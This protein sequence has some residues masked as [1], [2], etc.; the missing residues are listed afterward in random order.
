[1]EKCEAKVSAPT[2]RELLIDC[3]RET[4][5]LS[6]TSFFKKPPD[7]KVTIKDIGTEDTDKSFS[8][9]KFGETD[10]F[11]TKQRWQNNAKDVQSDTAFLPQ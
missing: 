9:L 2:N 5:T 7:K 8:P 4:E 6:L 11:I 10:H 1:M 3:M